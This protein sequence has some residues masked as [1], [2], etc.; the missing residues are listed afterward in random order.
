MLLGASACASR[1]P[2]NPPF[3]A[4]GDRRPPGARTPDRAAAA[5]V[6]TA[7]AL[8]GTPYRPGGQDPDTGFDCSGFVQWV[9]GRHGLGVPR[10]VANLF[11]S[12]DRVRPDAAP[13]AADLVFFDT[14]GRGP[15][16]VGIALGNGWFVHA[17]SSRGVVRVESL[18]SVYWAGRYLG[19]RRLLRP[20]QA[21]GTD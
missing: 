20:D 12:G 10:T 8:V 11:D 15:S 9:F 1:A 16:H 17:P 5:L 18:G 7:V 21:R 6:A 2:T 13:D 4:P 14:D 3:P 19:A